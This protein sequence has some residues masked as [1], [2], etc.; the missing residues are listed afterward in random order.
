ME[1]ALCE[2]KN[3][4]IILKPRQKKRLRPIK[5]IQYRI[6][7]LPGNMVAGVLNTNPIMSQ[8]AVKMR[9]CAA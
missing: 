1:H 5:L 6:T 2:H 9:S 3:T 7:S 4:E 8:R